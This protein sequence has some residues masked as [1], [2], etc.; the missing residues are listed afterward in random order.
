MP[1]GDLKKLAPSTDQVLHYKNISLET[2]VMS[3]ISAN[4]TLLFWEFE[5]FNN[6]EKISILYKIAIK[7][8][9]AVWFCSVK[10][11]R[12]KELLLQTTVHFI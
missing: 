7:C 4:V 6:Q 8:G 1:A 9:S 10:R 3:F 12:K 2:R 5:G 11:K